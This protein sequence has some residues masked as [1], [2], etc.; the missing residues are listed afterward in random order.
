M[1]YQTGTATDYAD[2]LN[3]LDAYLTGTGK[4]LTP[5]F[6]GIGNGL[7]V[8]VQGGAGSIAENITISFTA[9][10]TFN[11]AGSSTG[12]IGSGSLGAP[13]ASAE[14]SFQINLGSV[15]FVAGDVFTFSTTPPWASKRRVA[16]SEMIWQAPGNQNTDQILVGAFTFS[17]VPADDYN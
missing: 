3:R 11:V 13:F 6:T 7:I 4:C 10:N 17:S 5:Q 8:N 16:G 15:P 9:S 14:L 12:A 1:S 2:L